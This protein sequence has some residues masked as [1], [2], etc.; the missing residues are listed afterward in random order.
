MVALVSFWIWIQMQPPAE[1]GNGFARVAWYSYSM[2]SPAPE[3]ITLPVAIRVTVPG[4]TPSPATS[5]CGCVHEALGEDAGQPATLL[6]RV[7]AKLSVGGGAPQ[8]AG[9]SKSR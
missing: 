3:A 8:S 5:I 1:T 7:T 6:Q 2:R 9:T 4:V